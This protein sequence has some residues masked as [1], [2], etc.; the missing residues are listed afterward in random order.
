MNV[1][2]IEIVLLLFAG[3]ICVAAIGIGIVAYKTIIKNLKKQSAMKKCPFC[4]EMIQPDA[5][6][7][8]YCRRDLPNL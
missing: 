5:V 6:V 1:G 2:I 7:C 4:A 3:V 8:R